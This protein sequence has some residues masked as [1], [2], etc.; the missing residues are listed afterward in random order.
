MAKIFMRLALVMCFELIAFSQ[1]LAETRHTKKT[2]FKMHKT[3]EMSAIHAH[4]TFNIH[5][6]AGRDGGRDGAGTGD[7]AEGREGMGLGGEGGDAG[8]KEGSRWGERKGREEKH[9]QLSLTLGQTV[10][11]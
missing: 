1:M 7:G 8:W 9:Q 2:L 3:V 10:D 11:Q 5:T 6:E 4:K